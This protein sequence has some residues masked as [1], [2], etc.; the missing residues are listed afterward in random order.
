MQ[1]LLSW[2]Y[3]HVALVQGYILSLFFEMAAAIGGP[4]ESS[5]RASERKKF[6]ENFLFGKSIINADT[7]PFLIRNQK[8][9]QNCRGKPSWGSSSGGQ[10]F[11]WTFD[12]GQQELMGQRTQETLHI[13]PSIIFGLLLF[14]WKIWPAQ[15]HE[16]IVYAQKHGP[17][18]KQETYRHYIPLFGLFVWQAC[19][20]LEVTWLDVSAIQVTT[21]IW[22]MSIQSHVQKAAQQT[23]T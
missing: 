13:I 20:P 12:G 8:S 19:D 10:L 14:K 18:E 1:L 2:L 22:Y 7:Y 16:V 21:R 6:D 11:W 5:P 15:I 23:A 3:R 9:G 17:T 4:V